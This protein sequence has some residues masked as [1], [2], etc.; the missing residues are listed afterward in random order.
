MMIVVASLPTLGL[1]AYMLPT[2]VGLTYYATPENEWIEL[3][4][5]HLPEWLIP[6]GTGVVQN[7]FEPA[8]RSI[9]VPWLAWMPPLIFWTCFTF[10]LWG[11]MVCL[12]AILRRQWVVQEKFAFPLVQLPA[13]MSQAIPTEGLLNPFFDVSR[14]GWPF[15]SQLLS[16]LLVLYIFTILFSMRFHFDIALGIYLL[17]NLG[18][19]FVPSI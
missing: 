18:I 3:F 11:T 16:I 13:E 9:G 10:V 7:F 19:P 14:C 15:C 12:S 4:H 8:A 5:H 2:L 6:R 1:A 17:K